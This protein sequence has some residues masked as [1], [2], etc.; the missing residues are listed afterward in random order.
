[1][2]SIHQKNGHP[3]G[4]V[5][6]RSLQLTHLDTVFLCSLH[7]G[8]SITYPMSLAATTLSVMSDTLIYGTVRQRC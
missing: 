7:Q 6:A 4:G 1:M 3:S 8:R 5:H 2:K